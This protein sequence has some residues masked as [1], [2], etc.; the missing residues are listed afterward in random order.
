M[1]AAQDAGQHH[2]TY[3]ELAALYLPYNKAA[4]NTKNVSV[5]ISLEYTYSKY[6][7]MQIYSQQHQNPVK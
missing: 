2:G 1:G 7:N 5:W 6:I 3:V 4:S